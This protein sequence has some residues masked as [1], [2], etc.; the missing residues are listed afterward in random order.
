MRLINITISTT[1]CISKVNGPIEEK[2]GPIASSL[3]KE[4][5]ELN[6]GPVYL[7]NSEVYIEA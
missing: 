3:D 4:I 2:S 1:T 5:N 7:V 6:S